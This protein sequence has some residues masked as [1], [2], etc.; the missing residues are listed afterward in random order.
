MEIASEGFTYRDIQIKVG[1]KI[2]RSVH[3]DSDTIKKINM[4]PHIE[5]VV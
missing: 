4:K 2:K 5:S 1:N 3:F